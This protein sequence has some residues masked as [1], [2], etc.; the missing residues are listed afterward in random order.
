MNLLL[1]LAY[2]YLKLGNKEK[3][4]LYLKQVKAGIDDKY[5]VYTNDE[6]ESYEITDLYFEL[7]EYDVFLEKTKDDGYALTS[8]EHSFFVV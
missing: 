3:S 6:I 5:K 2:T 1:A 4:Y 8:W 7:E